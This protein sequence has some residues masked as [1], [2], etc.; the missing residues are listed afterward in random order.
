MINEAL[1]PL[2]KPTPFHNWLVQTCQIYNPLPGHVLL[3]LK[4]ANGTCWPAVKNTF[5]VP[6]GRNGDWAPDDSHQDQGNESR[7]TWL[8]TRAKKAVINGARQHSDFG[9]VTRCIQKKGEQ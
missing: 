5:V 6:P 9:E 8:R 3:L 4:V 2:K 7:D 1:H